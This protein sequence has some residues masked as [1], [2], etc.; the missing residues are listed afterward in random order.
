MLTF[1]MTSFLIEVGGPN[2]NLMDLGQ[3]QYI[4]RLVMSQK[5]TKTK[6]HFNLLCT[7]KAL[8]SGARHLDAL[9]RVASYFFYFFANTD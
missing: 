9:T 6:K 4:S 8:N 2:K 3:S 7:F 5:Q 1:L